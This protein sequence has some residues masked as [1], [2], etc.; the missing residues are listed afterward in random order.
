MLQW[1]AAE[2]LQKKGIKVAVYHVESIK[3]ILLNELARKSERGWVR[4]DLDDDYKDGVGKCIALDLSNETGAKLEVLGLDDR[5]AGF[6]K[7]VDNLPPDK[8]AIEKKVIEILER[9]VNDS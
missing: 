5:T 3:L 8:Y 1:K 6:D 2:L 9:K 4:F 7:K